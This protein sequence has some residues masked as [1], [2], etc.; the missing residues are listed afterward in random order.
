MTMED[1][2]RKVAVNWAETE[3]EQG[4]ADCLSGAAH[5]KDKS[6]PYKLGYSTKY[7]SEQIET[8]RG[9]QDERE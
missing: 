3:F 8:E 2:W 9:L 5:A 4:Q 6:Y 1:Y 7:E